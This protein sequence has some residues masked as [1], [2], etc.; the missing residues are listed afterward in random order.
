MNILAT[1]ESLSDIDGH[2]FSPQRSSDFESDDQRFDLDGI[3]LL[4]S[5]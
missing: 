5:G 3:E 4:L 2:I 1:T